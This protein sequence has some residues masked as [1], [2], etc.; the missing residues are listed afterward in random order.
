MEDLQIGYAGEGR[1]RT[2]LTLLTAMDAMLLASTPSVHREPTPPK[3]GPS[4]VKVKKRKMVKKS[5][6]Q[7]R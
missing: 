1:R 3:P 5:R 7:N 2:P 4:K 6:K